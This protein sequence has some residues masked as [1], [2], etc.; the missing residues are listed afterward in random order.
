VEEEIRI[1]KLEN[2]KLSEKLEEANK[3]LTDQQIV[4]ITNVTN[5]N[6]NIILTPWNSPH[7]PR[8]H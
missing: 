4:N 1:L 7:F 6:I 2:K 8:R 3:K 5:N